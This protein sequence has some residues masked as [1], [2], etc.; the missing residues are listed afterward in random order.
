MPII[1]DLL[2]AA[3]QARQSGDIDRSESLCRQL[4]TQDP[5]CGPAWHLLGSICS[6]RRR[7]EEALACHIKAAGLLSDVAEAHYDLGHAYHYIGRL[8]EAIAAY[9]RALVLAPT[10]FATN[11]NLG[12]ALQQQ[13]QLAEAAACYYQ[14]IET[15]PE[16]AE[17]HTFLGLILKD[18]GKFAE[19]IAAHRC[20][21]ELN[22]NLAIAHSNLAATLQAHNQLD[23][24]VTAYHRSLA[25]AQSFETYFNLGVAYQKLRRH[26]DAIR[27]FQQ[28]IQLH[29]QY[30]AAYNNLGVSCKDLGR[31]NE[32]FAAYQQALAIRPDY[33]E[34][35]NNLGAVYQ[36]RGELDKAVACFRRALELKP[37]FVQALSNLSVTFHDQDHLDD[38]AQSLEQALNIQPEFAD[39]YTYLGNIRKDQA[40]LDEAV[41][42]FRRALTQNSSSLIAHSNL[43][44]LLQFCPGITAADIYAEH[45]RFNA[46]HAAP[47]EKL[48]PPHTNDRN[49]NRRLRIGYVSPDFRNHCQILFTVPLLSRHNHADFEIF[50]YAN[51]AV[52]DAYT[53]QLQTYADHWRD[54]CGLSAPQTADLIRADQI[55]IL[56]DLTMHMKRSHLLVFAHKPAPVQICWLAYPGTTGLT[57][58][59]YRL[60]DPYLDP[61]GMFDRFYSE[62]SIRLPDTFW[63]YD[64][65]SPEPAVNDLP[66]LTTGHITF[67][68]LNNFCK[69]N[70]GTLDLFARILH[71]V[72]RSRLMLFVSEG[73][74]RDRTRDFFVQRGIAADRLTFV[75]R[76]SRRRYLEQYH[77]IDIGLDTLPYNGHTT[78]L[79]AF[80]MGVPVATL[81][82]QTVVGRAGLSQ[83]TNLDLTDLITYTTDQYLD[84]LVKLSSDL[85]RLSYLRSTLR[86][87]LQNSPLMNALLFTNNIENT[88]RTLWQRWCAANEK[89][90]HAEQPSPLPLGEG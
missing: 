48:A 79:D 12:A 24:A 36:E 53:A 44:Y 29:P 10:S 35:Q 74:H 64:P 82:G 8:P 67:G 11:A 28:S 20:A 16:F 49:P 6:S 78:S 70:D 50:C 38:A 2:S 17:A 90:L 9:R 46:Q 47:L 62:E 52:P 66:A 56:V 33:A 21:I 73:S 19:A 72:P 54:I 89:G 61:P 7:P 60:T 88:Y 13:G 39:A 68:S 22:P 25:L 81:V 14:A 3:Q 71:A 84:A 27:A 51:I 76:Q 58:I 1:P 18:Q 87:R 80:W 86:S 5:A 23:E 40:R 77:H 4:L 65:L 55:D 57:A 69:F 63:C 42:S 75:P 32:A 41:A 31:L 45:Q 37:S 15:K 59:D 26:A 43:C 34:A 83:L 30:A 85:P